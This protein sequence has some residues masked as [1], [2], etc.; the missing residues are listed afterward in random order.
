MACD[1]LRRKAIRGGCFWIVGLFLAGLCGCGGSGEPIVLKIDGQE[2]TGAEFKLL[3]ST[4]LAK[5]GLVMGTPEGNAHLR[6]IAP[7]V[8]ETLITVNVIKQVAEATVEPASEEEL[9]EKLALFKENLE[10]QG[11]DLNQFLLEMGLDLDEAKLVISNQ[12]R[13]DRLQKKIMEEGR[14]KISDDA[15]KAYYYDREELFRFPYR[16]RIAHILFA[17][18]DEPDPVEQRMIKDKA[19]RLQSELADG[20]AEAF[21]KAAQEYSQD[22]R[23]G[24]RGGDMGFV[25]RESLPE[26]LADAI[27]EGTPGEIVG[28]ALSP[29]GY[30]LALVTDTEMSFEEA[31]DD[32]K[33]FLEHE[34]MSRHFDTW[35][36][37]RIAEA[38]V[39][40]LVD[41]VEF[42]FPP[43][44]KN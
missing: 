28:P 4:T 3:C 37:E 42:L 15:L 22:I 18:G 33:R 40:R 24:P 7:N 21:A 9:D 17:L 32:V 44:E 23:S 19:E 16:A 14:P 2:I 39:E 26:G 20:G 31:L 27:F 10:R 12:D 1:R 36:Q 35:L 5:S 11:T 41:P 43:A 29:H 13:V 30:H 34:A 6:Q 8:F 38:G 25:V